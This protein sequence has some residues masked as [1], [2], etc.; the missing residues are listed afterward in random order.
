MSHNSW[1]FSRALLQLKYRELCRDIT[2]GVEIKFQAL[3]MTPY[4]YVCRRETSMR[5]SPLCSDFRGQH[6]K[7]TTKEQPNCTRR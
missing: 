7:A 2:S 5:T 1:Q 4:P 3:N 6:K